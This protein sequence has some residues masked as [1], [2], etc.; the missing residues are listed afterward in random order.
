M[1]LSIE[2]LGF[3]RSTAGH[4]IV[5]VTA[6][7]NRN[8]G[9]RQYFE[10][11]CSCGFIATGY[12][13][14]AGHAS[15]WSTR[16]WN[17][18]VEGMASPDEIYT[19]GVIHKKRTRWDVFVI[20]RNYS[21]A[22]D[23]E[24]RW[25][26]VRGPH[27]ETAWYEFSHWACVI[28]KSPSGER[29]LSRTARTKDQAVI[30]GRKLLTAGEHGGHKVE[31][32]VAAEPDAPTISPKASLV[33]FV[34]RVDEALTSRKLGEAKG[35][36]DLLDEYLV[37]VPILQSKRAALADHVMELMTLGMDLN[38]EQTEENETEV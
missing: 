1:S 15:G 5:S 3:S 16:Y 31:W 13:T 21:G 17:E 32:G 19:I 23:Y 7:P 33:A 34:E 30:A 9:G 25:G 27:S 2:K 6:D 29:V 20:S 4:K 37:S 38:D 8:Y 18:H 36:L 12:V 26:G 24:Y 11:V 28:H 10:A 22:D 14:K 35:A